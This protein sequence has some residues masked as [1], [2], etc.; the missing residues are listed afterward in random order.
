MKL[1]LSLTPCINQLK[2]HK[3]AQN[4]AKSLKAFR[5][6]KKL[7][8]PGMSSLVLEKL[9]YILEIIYFYFMCMHILLECMFNVCVQCPQK[10]GKDIRSPRTGV[11]D[12]CELT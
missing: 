8:D 6:E 10:P 11:I 12:S 4:K 7:S 1:Y 5:R 9:C 3:I 2:L